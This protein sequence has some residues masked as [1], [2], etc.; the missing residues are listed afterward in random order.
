MDVECPKY[1]FEN[2]DTQRFYGEH[3]TQIITKEEISVTE[4]LET[5]SE[6]L[7]R[8]VHRDLKQNCILIDKGRN[9]TNRRREDA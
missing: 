6:E 3:G 9:N 4:T 8:G 5:R 1:Q 7:A 2:P